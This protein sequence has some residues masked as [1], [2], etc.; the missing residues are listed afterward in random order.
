MR[1]ILP[2]RV[3][4]VIGAWRRPRRTDVASVDRHY[5]SFIDGR[6]FPAERRRA[7]V[8]WTSPTRRDEWRTRQREEEYF[9]LLLNH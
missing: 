5:G 1:A 4:R 9:L 8:A 2:G 6:G 3:H 7:E